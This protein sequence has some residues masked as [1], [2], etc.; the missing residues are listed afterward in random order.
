MARI[1]GDIIMKKI[2]LT[3]N[4]FA[5]VDDEDFD[6][7]NQWKWC[8]ISPSGKGPTKKYYA[9][10]KMHGKNVY[11]HRLILNPDKNVVTDHIDSDGL[12]NQRYNLRKVTYKQN[13]Q[14][15]RGN[16]NAL[17]K[18][19]GVSLFSK[20]GFQMKKYRIRIHI[21]NGKIIQKLFYTII[22]AAIAY[23]RLALKHFG[24]YAYTNFQYQDRQG[25][26]FK[27]KTIHN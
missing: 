16:A 13:R 6:Y 20:N 21:G 18:Y 12:N 26:R 2:P 1:F 24:E 3:Q 9:F 8:V 4:Q 25:L 10:R 7:L 5:L 15:A 11:M 14:N 22:E 23:D 27:L 17:I 19:K